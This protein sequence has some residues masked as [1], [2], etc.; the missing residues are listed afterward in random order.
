[1]GRKGVKINMRILIFSD[2]HGDTSA[3]AN[4]ID[5]I[6][7][8]DVI[9]HAGDHASDA[10]MLKIRYPEKEFFFVPGNCDFSTLPSTLVFTLCEKNIFLTHGHTYNVKN[11]YKYQKLLQAASSSDAQMAIFGHTHQPYYENNGNL[12]LLNP[13]S[14]K[15][16][17]T[18]AIAEIENGKLR[19][20]ICNCDMWN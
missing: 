20:D 11:D 6:A 15:H 9:I 19:A 8:T 1:M 7:G 4:I 14:I 18:F 5:K 10:Q 13:G 17:R 3:C 12:I 2:S 16:S